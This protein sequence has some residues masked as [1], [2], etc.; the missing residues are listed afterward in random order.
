MS[1]RKSAWFSGAALAP[2]ANTTT[3]AASAAVARSLPFR[4]AYLL[5]APGRWSGGRRRPVTRSRAGRGEG[6]TASE[7]P[8]GRASGTPGVCLRGMRARTSVTQA[9]SLRVTRE[10][11]DLAI[12]NAVAAELNREMK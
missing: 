2:V 8:T 1:L 9:E 3:A 7:K 6:S 11:R 10:A 12:L 5:V 4:I